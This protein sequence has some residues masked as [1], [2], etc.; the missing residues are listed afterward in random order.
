MIKKANTIIKKVV[1]RFVFTIALVLTA[2]TTAIAQTGF[3]DDVDD[4]AAP[5]PID[6]YVFL[7]AVVGI[8]FV[9]MKIR[10]NAKYKREINSY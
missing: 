1:I 10:A 5:A 3:G 2:S 8:I 9:L 6:D 7:L 4:T